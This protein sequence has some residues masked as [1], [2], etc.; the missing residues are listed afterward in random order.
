MLETL[1]R[2][3][4]DFRA[5]RLRAFNPLAAPVVVRTEAKYRRTSSDDGG[6]C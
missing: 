5:A 1:L 2:Q 6:R 3:A 4:A